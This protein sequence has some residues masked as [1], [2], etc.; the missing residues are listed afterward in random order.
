[1]LEFTI[2]HFYAVSDKEMHMRIHTFDRDALSTPA[3]IRTSLGIIHD[4]AFR[5]TLTAVVPPFDAVPE[6]LASMAEA[7]KSGN[8]GFE[9]SIR[10]MEALHFDVIR[11]TVD[12]RRQSQV[13]SGVRHQINQLEDL[14]I[15]IAAIRELS[16][17]T[18]DLV[19]SWAS[20]L[21][22]YVFSEGLRELRPDVHLLDTR[23]IISTDSSFTRA[24]VRFEESR[25]TIRQ[26][27][28]G[29]ALTT[30]ATGGLGTTPAGEVTTLGLSGS[31][32]SASVIAAAL[33]AS[34]LTVWTLTDGILTGDPE[35][36]PAARPIA[37][38]T[39]TEAMEMMHFGGNFLY[40]PA[41]IPAIKHKIPIRVRN[42]LNPTFEGSVLSDTCGDS[43]HFTGISSMDDIALLRIQGN[44]MVG[45]TGVSMR[46][47]SALAYAGINVILI[48]QAS[49]EHS[50]CV[51]IMSA[52]AARAK[53]AVEE[54][55]AAELAQGLIDDV[56]A[57]ENLSIVAV[58][59]ER[60]RRTMG[61]AAKI[62]GTLAR[63][64][65]NI[66]A[67]AQGSSEQNVSIVID[68]ADQRRALRALHKSL[69]EDG[70]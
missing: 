56:A 39:Y 5:G 45:V 64:S 27:L 24:R 11:E 15:G 49:S 43:R 46:L 61:L 14:L 55:F 70:V 18:S 22:A 7:A 42:I 6:L 35:K 68:A 63:E 58:V 57:D 53:T 33:E 3:L 2:T 60:M 66:K 21:A 62:F 52:D 9:P 20:W 16:G 34:E 47:F 50:I 41:L 28:S 59:G 36:V 48:S 26:R 25:E 54:N 4:E 29:T 51:G 13:I 32:L 8:T 23:E 37:R 44:G 19:A 30:V 31:C 10:K 40:P 1:M 17:R 69:I 67:I 65:V 12:V 38:M